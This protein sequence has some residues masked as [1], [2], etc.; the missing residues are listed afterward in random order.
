MQAASPRSGFHEG[1]KTWQSGVV[2]PAALDRKETRGRGHRV[3]PY[4][5]QRRKD[6]ESNQAAVFPAGS[7][8]DSQEQLSDSFS[9]RPRDLCAR[10]DLCSEE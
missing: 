4:L 3:K 1:L 9:L 5:T 2:R 8:V 6:A 10:I 7:V